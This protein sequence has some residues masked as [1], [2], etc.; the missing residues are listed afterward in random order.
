MPMFKLS[1]S[2]V[3]PLTLGVF[4]LMG[5]TGGL[6]FFHLDSGLNKLA[7]EW[8]GWLMMGAVAGHALLNWPALKRH[9][10]V[11]RPAQ[12]IVGLSLAALALSFVPAGAEGGGVSPPV[13]A[14]RAVSRAPVQDLL[15]LA[16]KDLAQAQAELAAAGLT[17]RDGSQTLQAI[18]GGDRERLGRA[19]Q[20]LL[21][22]PAS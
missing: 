12:L 19:V 5:V 18:T 20:V 3:T 2:W 14:L 10:T 13:A 11:S 15:P 21:A 6:M 1:R 8:L 16:G 22:A 7:H 9:L 4:L 17:L